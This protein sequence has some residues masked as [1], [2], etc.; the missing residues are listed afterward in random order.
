MPGP[1]PEDQLPAL[2]AHA[3]V[4]VLPSLYEGF[5]MPVLEAM[6]AGCPVV[7]STVSSLPEVAG[8]AA[9]LVDPTDT[10]AIASGIGEARQ[11]RGELQV[12]GFKRAQE[13]TWERTAHETL[14]VLLK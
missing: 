6:A 5:G 3:E 10:E 7:T 11:R 2:Y 13:F 9:V 12:K 8:D 14:C 1:V 4:F